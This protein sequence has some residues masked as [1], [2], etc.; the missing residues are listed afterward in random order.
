MNAPFKK[1]AMAI[2]WLAVAGDLGAAACPA[3]D[4][5]ARQSLSVYVQKKFKVPATSRV[6]LTELAFVA[7]TCYRRLQFKTVNAAKPLNVELIASPDL[8]FLTF[9]LLDSQGDPSEQMLDRSLAPAVGM[10]SSDAPA[11][12]PA[13]APV[14]IVIFSDFECPY[15]AQLAKGL[16]KD[17]IP[18][19]G[20]KLRVEFRHYPLPMHSWARA[21]A[22]AAACAQNQ[23]A[24]YFWDFHDFMFAHQKE[25]TKDNLRLTILKHASSI[26]GFN[27][28]QYTG[29]VDKGEMA[30]V[31]EKDIAA[32]NEIGISA[33]PTLF[34]NGQVVQGYHREQIQTLIREYISLESTR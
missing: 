33:T 13:R 4:Q 3:L 7:D 2:V 15:C 9:D 28:E 6:N 8:R 22:E 24:P 31:V 30:P 10:R 19:E 34:V 21:A 29:C 25:I 1:L 18:E 23:G 11:I 5:G 27:V 17:I 16:A 14:T 12:G 20:E 32:G 26:G